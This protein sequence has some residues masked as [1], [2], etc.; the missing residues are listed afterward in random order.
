[1][2]V[3][4]YRVRFDWSILLLVAALLL[5]SVSVSAQDYT[6][7]EY[8]EYQDAVAKGEDAM[9]AF[10]QGH[11]DS[12]LNQ[13]VVAAY[14]QKLNDYST[15]AQWN[16]AYEAGKKF[17]DTVG[18]DLV[19]A[20]NENR[21]LILAVTTWAAYNS[22]HYAEA[23][24]FGSKLYEV[25]P[26]TDNLVMILARSYLNAGDVGN[27][28]KWGEK[29]CS[30]VT[31][32]NCFDILPTLMRYYAEQKKWATASKYAQQTIDALA[33]AP[34]PAQVSEAEWKKYTNEEVSVAHTIIGR[35]AFES[36]KWSTCEKNY[37]SVFSLTPANH[38]RNAEAHYYIGMSRWSQDQIDP[39]MEAF[40]RGVA[41]GNTP[42]KETCQKQLEKLYRAT[43]NG[44]LAG[45]DELLERA[46]TG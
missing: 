39:A 46:T 1:M 40:A 13:Y 6:I 28:V 43:H 2:F 30:T 37:S 19:P 17:L 9:I 35:S 33:K 31:P 32:E 12:S 27:A 7:E 26:N 15:N 25:Q 10:I 20:D 42:Y 3:E 4:R 11:P 14:Q 21:L 44:S 29:Y 24:A 22:Q 18:T 34:K 23:A 5:T 41:Q 8:N 38:E 16:Q 45:L 36:K